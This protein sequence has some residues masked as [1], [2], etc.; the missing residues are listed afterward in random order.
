MLRAA[1]A[2]GAG[3]VDGAAVGAVVVGGVE[4]GELVAGADVVDVVD[5][6]AVVV[7]DASAADPPADVA[8]LDPPV[9]VVVVAAPAIEA[10]TTVRPRT[11]AAKTTVAARRARVVPCTGREL[12]RDLIRSELK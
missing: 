6:G 10:G 2:E 1:L 3:A 12:A 7:V 8:V 11:V 4:L 9:V 5:G